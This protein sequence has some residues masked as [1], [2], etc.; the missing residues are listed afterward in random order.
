MILAKQ[1]LI[2]NINSGSIDIQRYGR[3][4]NIRTQIS[5]NSI[6]LT[7][8][9]FITPIPKGLTLDALT[10]Q[11]TKKNGSIYTPK[12]LEMRPNSKFKLHADKVYLACTNERI[13]SQDFVPMLKDKS[14]IGR[15]FM[16]TH[17]NAG[18]GDL[19]FFGYLTLEIK[20]TFDTWVTPDMAIVQIGFMKASSS[21]DGYRETGRYNNDKPY[22]VVS[23]GVKILM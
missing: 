23:K 15:M 13:Y 21:S 7:L 3:D 19:G 22:P 12:M 20:P 18:W 9:P 1:E 11:F 16:P 5:E 17:F 2:E 4:F 14:S 10:G 8:S 6:D